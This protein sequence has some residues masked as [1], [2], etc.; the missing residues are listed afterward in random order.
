MNYYEQPSF[1]PIIL[2]TYSEG[3]LTA[4]LTVLDEDGEYFS[5]D[6]FITDSEGYL[7]Y[8]NNSGSV[9]QTEAMNQFE[10][11]LDCFFQVEYA[12]SMNTEHFA[13]WMQ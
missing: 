7:K 4:E 12:E 10:L 9:S 13:K 5:A 8:Q 3:N 11:D 6:V 1:Q 2:A